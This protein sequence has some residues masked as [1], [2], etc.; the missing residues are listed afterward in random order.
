MR[1]GT[2]AMLTAV[3]VTVLVGAGVAVAVAAPAS[4]PR[5]SVAAGSVPGGGS[6][7]RSATWAAVRR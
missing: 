3:A 6:Q 2:R 7:A 1:Y 5:A 4:G